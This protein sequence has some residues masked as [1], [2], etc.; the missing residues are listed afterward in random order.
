ATLSNWESLNLIPGEANVY[1]E[2]AFIGKIYFDTDTTKEE[3]VVGLGVDPQI[4]VKREDKRDFKAKSFFG[5]NRIVSKNYEIT[6]KNN[7][8]KTVVVKL[9][10]RVPISGNSEI[11]VDE[12]ETGTA[13]VDKETQ[14]LTWEI[15]LGSGSQVQERFS[16]RVKYPKRRRINL[17]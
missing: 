17:E 11:K 6:L 4:S 5:N 3:L 9:Q 12:V 16:Y 7:R 14:I 10:D 13:Q 2:D 1:F 8:N 15:N